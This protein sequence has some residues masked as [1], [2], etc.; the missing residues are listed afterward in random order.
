MITRRDLSE[1][2]GQARQRSTVVSLPIQ[3]PAPFY[4][5]HAGRAVIQELLRIRSLGMPRSAVDRFF[6][7]NSL[8]A[9]ARPW[10]VGARGEIHVGQMLDTLPQP[11]VTFH[12]LPIG[13]RG[14]DVD[15]LIIGPGGIF[16][17]NT[18][19]HRQARVRIY[20]KSV[21]VNGRSYPY[22]RNS[23]YEA[24]RIEKLLA[25]LATPSL[26]VTPVLAFFE[27]S[28]V[29][30]VG[31]H[32]TVVAL[33]SRRLVRHLRARPVQLTPAEI[34]TIAEFVD[35]L[36]AWRTVESASDPAVDYVKIRTEVQRATSI[37]T[38]WLFVA[39]A[40][41]MIAVAQVLLALPNAI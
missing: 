34:S 39:P 6:G 29:V 18:K 21:W 10:Y 27:P 38:L 37:R 22:I 23:E 36:P 5:R 25:P 32:A 16:A 14:S 1:Q 33:D 28:S 8:T 7:L 26:A 15:H 31:R 3:T 19:S 24:S 4:G 35:S 9:Q 11:W 13:T 41:V 20:P 30:D 40:C 17:I 12:S 2:G